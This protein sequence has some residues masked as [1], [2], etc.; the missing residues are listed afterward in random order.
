[1]MR[2]ALQQPAALPSAEVLAALLPGLFVMHTRSKVYTSNVMDETRDKR[3]TDHFAYMKARKA[4]RQDLHN[5]YAQWRA[6]IK[7]KELDDQAKQRQARAEEARLQAEHMELL[8]K[9]KRAASLAT[10]LRKAELE[11]KVEPGGG[12][13]GGGKRRASG[14][15]RDAAAD[16][17]LAISGQTKRI[18]RVGV[19][20]G[21]RP[22]RPAA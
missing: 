6:E 14:V 2:T 11:H 10:E 19:E 20:A 3:I 15:G 5:L 9:E 13:G 21:S 18:G 7:A 4:Y 1:M 8:L 12:A 17:A 22:D 16:R